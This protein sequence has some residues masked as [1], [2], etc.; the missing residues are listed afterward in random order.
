MHDYSHNQK[1]C[2]CQFSRKKIKNK[3]FSTL[4][5]YCAASHHR[6]PCQH[7]DLEREFIG[8]WTTPEFNL[9]VARGYIIREMFEVWHH[10]SKG[11]LSSKFIDTCMAAKVAN[12]GWSIG[13][14]TDQEKVKYSN[15]L[16]LKDNI[17]VNV[18]CV[19]NDP[20]MRLFAKFMLNIL[21]DRLAIQDNIPKFEYV[22]SYEQFYRVF[23][24]NQYE[25]QYVNIL[26]DETFQVQSV[27]LNSAEVQDFRSNVVVAS[28]VTSHARMKLYRG[29]EFVGPGRLVYVDTDCVNSLERAHRPSLS[30][31]N[32][33]GDF[34]SE[35]GCEKNKTFR[36]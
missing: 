10:S 34:K 12:S 25:I 8:V 32:C 6:L 17:N 21:W 1:H 36:L 19:Q 16:C 18:N 20:T 29:M 15:N 33:V 7:T 4:C 5:T 22:T 2:T 35:T 3:C 31:G 24:S 9:A 26:V 13:C 23:Y 28:F 11:D 30:I 14:Y 27:S